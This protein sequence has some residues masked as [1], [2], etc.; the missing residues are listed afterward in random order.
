FKTGNTEMAKDHL[1][2]ALSLAEEINARPL[3]RD[4]YSTLSQVYASKQDYK[5]AYEF[6]QL[7]K[8]YHDSLLN[9]NIARQ[10]NELHTLY[11]SE[12]KDQQI[13]QLATEKELQKSE[14]RREKIMKRASIIGLILLALLG[15][16]ISYTYHQKLRNQKLLAA[17]DNEIN[18]AI[19]KRQVSDLEMKA[20][21]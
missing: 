18:E 2:R 21:R 7:F 13:T 5:K 14:L 12:K 16:A 17:K 15:I 19:F 10:L 3:L 11:E 4:V 6:D 8:S 20:L 9:E 1:S